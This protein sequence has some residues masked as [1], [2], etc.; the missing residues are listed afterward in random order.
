MSLSHAKGLPPNQHRVLAD[1]TPG[2]LAAPGPSMHRM[3]F[4][5]CRNQ[6][7]DPPS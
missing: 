1:G 2:R 7:N 5:H 6:Q 4:M 3:L